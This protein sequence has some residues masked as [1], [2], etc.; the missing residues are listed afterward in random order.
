MKLL[1]L[2]K[3]AQKSETRDQER[4]EIRDKEMEFKLKRAKVDQVSYQVKHFQRLLVHRKDDM[5]TENKNI[6]I[7]GVN[8]VTTAD[9][10][11]HD[12]RSTIK[13]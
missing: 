10:G 7:K 3:V 13:V 12:E 9:K 6:R 1:S 5:S 4:K 2:G 8:L 11:I